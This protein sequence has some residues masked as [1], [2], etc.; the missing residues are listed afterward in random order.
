MKLFAELEKSGILVAESFG[1]GSLK[2]QLRNANKL[3]VDIA[4]IVGQKEALD[5][6]VIV[7]NMVAGTQETVSRE[8]LMTAIKKILKSRLVVSKHK[9]G[10]K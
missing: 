10:S 8:K 5:E 7:K 2:T 9:V 1:R 6:T 3:G 4:L